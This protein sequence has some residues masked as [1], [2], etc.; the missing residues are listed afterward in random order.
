MKSSLSIKSFAIL[1]AFLLVLTA[2][3]EI[4]LFHVGDGAALPTATLTP[5]GTA[6]GGS[7][8]TFV[9]INDQN[10]INF[11]GQTASVETQTIVASAGGWEMNVGGDNAIDIKCSSPDA[12]QNGSCDVKI[13]GDSGGIDSP[14]TGSMVPEVFPVA[15]GGSGSGSGSSSTGSGSNGSS[16]SSPPTSTGN[17]GANPSASGSNSGSG[18][19][20]GSS[21]SNANGAGGL[22]MID[23][24]YVGL[25]IGSVV[26]GVLMVA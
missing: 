18:S 15:G 19:S 20:N 4:T 13:G 8:T 21:G 1:N 7:A 9:F 10:E 25:V 11:G 24:R 22:G 6:D 16:S 26:T 17:A 23:M 2:A 12:Q 14:A 5:V 3:D